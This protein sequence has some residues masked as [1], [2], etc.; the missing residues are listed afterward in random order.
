MQYE[1]IDNQ[2]T[3]YSSENEEEIYAIFRHMVN[4][5]DPDILDTWQGDLKLVKVLEVER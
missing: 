2:G 1:I 4:Q 3:I 5:D